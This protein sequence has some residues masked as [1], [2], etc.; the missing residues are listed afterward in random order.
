MSGWSEIL[1][2]L[3]ATAQQDLPNSP[4]GEVDFDGVRRRY[5]RELAEYTGRSTILY[6]SD[7][8]NP[9]KQGFGSMASVTI[10]DVYGLMEVF[11]D[12][13]PPK[14][15]L[16]IHSPGGQVEAAAK[17][18]EYMRHRYAHIRVIVPMAAMSAATILACAADE[19]IM[20]AHSQLG[21]IDP[22]ILMPTG[23]MASGAL[24]RQFETMRDDIAQHPERLG[25]YVP[26]LQQYPPGLLDVCER[27][28]ELSR[29]VVRDS[30]ARYMFKNRKD[31]A[32]RA[33]AIA[34]KLSDSELHLSHGRPLGPDYL[35]KI[36]FKITRL[37]HNA[38]LQDKALSVFHATQHTFSGTLA[39][40]LIENNNGRALV[41]VGLAPTG[42]PFG[43]RL[44][45]MIPPAGPTPP[46]P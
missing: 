34:D 31:A 23:A 36:G 42:V 10:D 1:A 37:E 6:A 29:E 40:K 26:I 12:L 24:R 11:K 25:A 4:I 30:L 3:N 45:P 35:E 18:I 43:A 46:G 27:A 2:E 44:T 41:R 7:F 17:M 21:P 16:I 22:Q 20:G 32:R 9:G 5:L 33:A 38:Q 8:T 39:V 14:L 15:D 13:K 19:I 28:E